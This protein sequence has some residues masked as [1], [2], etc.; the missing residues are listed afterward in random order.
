MDHRS[1]LDNIFNIISGL[2]QGHDKP[3]KHAFYN[4][5]GLFVLFLCCAA[6]WA[7]YIILQ[8]F[9]KPLVWALLVG[10]VLHPIKHGLR[11]QFRKWFQDIDDSGTPILIGI[12]ILPVNIIN[13]ISEF[14]GSNLVK[15]IKPIIA[16]GVAIPAVL[17]LYYYTPS[18]ICT[19]VWNI[20]LL[21]YG[22]VNFFINN[23]SIYA[24]SIRW[25]NEALIQ[26]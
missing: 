3:V 25:N 23:A 17:A 16:V 4:A 2:P 20:L 5:V 9:I 12:C 19:C 13:N 6:G 7:L 10:S 22:I 1:P 26:H 11:E 24:V 8:P 18:V 14:I 15:Y 21:V